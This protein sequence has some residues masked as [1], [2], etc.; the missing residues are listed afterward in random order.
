MVDVPREVGQ[1]GS[2]CEVIDCGL[3][4]VADLTSLPGF[5]VGSISVSV[6]AYKSSVPQ[7]LSVS[8]KRSTSDILV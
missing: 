7:N 2:D 4:L 8:R 6:P 3:V 1:C 5:V